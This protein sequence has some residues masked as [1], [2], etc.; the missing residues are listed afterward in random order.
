MPWVVKIKNTYD[1]LSQ[2]EMEN[3]ANI[4]FSLIGGLMTLNAF[5]GI[6]GNVQWESY[7]NPGQWQ[8]SFAVGDMDGGYGLVMWT[9]ARKI[10]DIVG[11]DGDAQTMAIVNLTSND[12]IPTASY[13]QSFEEFKRLSSEP[14]HTAAVFCYN[15][16]R[17][18]SV[19]LAE[20]QTY[21]R[22][23]YNYFYGK[24]PGPGPGPGPGPAPVSVRRMKIYM[25]LNKFR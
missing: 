16:E 5:A 15:Y 7:I 1:S 9:P 22:N 17:A 4:M 23:W 20:R 12:W 14:E 10:F 2:A 13:P 18:G 11:Y 6:L 24:E 21:A 3:N 19:H 25:Y 8:G